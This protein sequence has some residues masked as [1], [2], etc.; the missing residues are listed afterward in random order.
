MIRVAYLSLKG[1]IAVQTAKLSKIIKLI[2]VITVEPAVK[3]YFA[4]K[5]YVNELGSI[6]ATLSSPVFVLTR[7]PEQRLVI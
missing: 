4:F 3:Y 1:T 6:S 5:K 7:F 2:A